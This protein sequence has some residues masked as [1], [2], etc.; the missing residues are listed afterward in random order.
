MNEI[1]YRVVLHKETKHLVT[2]FKFENDAT[3]V[4]REKEYIIAAPTYCQEE[5]EV[6]MVMV[7]SFT[8][9]D[10]KIIAAYFRKKQGEPKLLNGISGESKSHRMA[11]ENI[12]EGILSGEIKIDGEILNKNI[13]ED[14]KMEYRTNKNGYVIP[15]VV[16]LLKEPHPKYGLGIFFEIQFS[17]QKNDKTIERTYDR[18]IRGLSG[19]WLNKLDFD[20]SYKFIKDNIEIKSHKELLLEIEQET[21]NKFIKRINNYGK[22]IDDKFQNFESKICNISNNKYKELFQE[23]QEISKIKSDIYESYNLWKEIDVNTISNEIAFEVKEI[24]KNTIKNI[25]EE[26]LDIKSKHIENANFE[27]KNRIESNIK[28]IKITSIFSK[29]CPICKK[30]MRVGKS[31]HGMNWYCI[32]YPKCNGFKKNVKIDEVLESES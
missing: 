13:I 22:I 32:D 14:I 26:I 16:V 24:L 3:W 31:I 6:K 7:H 12:Y 30:D 4:G 15:D 2:A 8:K 5:K 21:E 27:I 29:K 28:N 11:K 19:I 1:K 17:D 23:N 18:V 20:I 10:G 9:S 25:S